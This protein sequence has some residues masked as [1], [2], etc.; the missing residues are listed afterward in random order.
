[1]DFK[2]IA[3]EMIFV[4]E[5]IRVTALRTHHL[6]D[7]ENPEPTYGYKVDFADGFRLF[8][9]GD[10]RND[11]SDFRKSSPRRQAIYVFANQRILI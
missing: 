10:L 9:T 5:N 6:T 3:P 7:E 8:Y 11:F 2:V 4:D 1:M